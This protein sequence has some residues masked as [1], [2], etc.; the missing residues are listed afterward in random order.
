MKHFGPDMGR[1]PDLAGKT[2]EQGMYDV[3]YDEDGSATRAVK[4]RQSGGYILDG[5]HYP[6]LPVARP[7]KE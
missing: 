5:I 7:S 3:S 1:R 2:I 4:I 6:G